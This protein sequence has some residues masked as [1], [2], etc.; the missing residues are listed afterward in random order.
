M[1]SPAKPLLDSPVDLLR[2]NEELRRSLTQLQAEM[3]TQKAAAD[4]AAEQL[5]QFLYA[6]SHDLQEPLRGIITYTQLLERQPGADPASDEYLTFILRGA[7]QMRELL[8]QLLVYSRAGSA[9]KY[10]VLNLN[11]PLQ[12]ALLKLAPEI[13]ASGAQISH[14]PL[15]EAIGDENEISQVFHHIL[16][17]SLKFHSKARP[18][19]SVAGEQGTDECTITVRD[20]GVG[21]EPRFCEQVLLPFKRLHG[22]EIEGN[23][24]G[25]AICSKIL[26]AHQGR[27]WVESDGIRGTAV[28]FTLPV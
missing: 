14:N 10:R 4:L 1:A 24:L 7:L 25:L 23:G 13:R 8:Q 5:Q 16:S 20:N 15:P 3:A 18:E 6:A 21:I 11:V 17:N 28:H 26:R 9:K 2:E 27:I 22:H 19:I 12:M